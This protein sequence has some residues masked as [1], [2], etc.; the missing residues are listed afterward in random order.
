MQII[1]MLII[2]VLSTPMTGKIGFIHHLKEHVLKF[3]KNPTLG[4]KVKN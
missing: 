1:H 2:Q 3:K 4:K